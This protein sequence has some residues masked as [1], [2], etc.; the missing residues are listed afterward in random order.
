MQVLTTIE[1]AEVFVR[2]NYHPQILIL[3]VS[4][5]PHKDNIYECY[6]KNEKDA[7]TYK[8]K[9]LYTVERLFSLFKI[10]RKASC[11]F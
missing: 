11:K 2:G 4:K 8:L 6:H 5:Q 7:C 3:P 9:A 10:A 1:Q